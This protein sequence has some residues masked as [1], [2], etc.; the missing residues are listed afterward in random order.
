MPGP[1]LESW[2]RMSPEGPSD[3]PFT[4]RGQLSAAAPPAASP[5]AGGWGRRWASSDRACSWPAS[6]EARTAPGTG[7]RQGC[8]STPLHTR[9]RPP[10][11]R[12]GLMSGGADLP[13]CFPS[14]GLLPRRTTL[15]VKAHRKGRK[16]RVCFSGNF[17]TQTVFFS[18]GS[19]VGWLQSLVGT[20]RLGLGSFDNN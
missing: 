18:Q 4:C 5:A 8:P 17:S 19:H 11:G 15:V 13:G 16:W 1:F 20:V 2:V 14:T 12:K 10:A 6:G 7:S 3:W 9:N